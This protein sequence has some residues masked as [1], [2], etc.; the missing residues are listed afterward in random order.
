MYQTGGFLKVAGEKCEECTL[1]GRPVMTGYGNKDADILLV[2]EAPVESEIRRGKPFVSRAGELLD[3]ILS[4]VNIDREDLWITNTCL[5]QPTE[6]KSPTKSE[7]Q[8]CY[9]RLIS[10][11]KEVNPTV[12][13]TMGN[14]ALEALTGKKGITKHI[15]SYEYN[16]TLDAWVI[17]SIHPAAGLR[18]PGWQRDLEVAF[19]LAKSLVEKATIG[20]QIPIH[21]KVIDNPDDFYLRSRYDAVLDLEWSSDQKVLC[22]GLGNEDEVVIYDREVLRDPEVVEEI[23][24][25]IRMNGLIGQNLKSDI[26]VLARDKELGFSDLTLMSTWMDPDGPYRDDTMLMS[27]ALDA[28]KGI[29][30]LKDLAKRLLHVG[31]YDKPI[32]PYIKEMENC[33]K[34][35]M[36]KYNAMDVVYNSLIAKQLREQMNDRVHTLYTQRLMP[37]A[38]ALC[39]MEVRGTFINRLEL[40][41]LESHFTKQL[42][43][44]IQ[45][46]YL[47][48]G[49]EFNIN[50]HQQLASILYD[51]MELPIPL[52]R[53]VNKEAFAMLEEYH[54]IIPAIQQYK[55]LSKIQGTYVQGVASKI[56]PLG[57]IHT[58]FNIHG[59]T[60]GRLSS[61][62]PNLQNIPARTDLGKK[63]K[64]VFIPSRK[65]YT[66]F[67]F[68][69][70]QAE[71]RV[72]A[73][74]SGD[75]TLL[76]AFHNDK[77]IHTVTSA[78]IFGVPMDEVTEE[79]RNIGKTCNF[80]ILYGVSPYGLKK[81]INSTKEE[82]AEAI[83]GWFATYPRAEEFM[84]KQQ[85]KALKEGYVETVTGRVREFPAVGPMNASIM[86]MAGNTPV[87][88][89]AS[90]ITLDAVIRIEKVS[91][92][93][94]FNVLLTVHDSVLLE[95][96]ERTFDVEMVRGI[97][98]KTAEEIVEGKVP[99]VVDVKKGPNWGDMEE[100]E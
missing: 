74:L 10:E 83:K 59:T 31:E 45:E 95:A 88:G 4:K 27:Y 48:A 65:D 47:M 52:Q 22:M 33:P 98:L 35:L 66:L 3:A 64:K 93:L 97:M 87:Q 67:E 17:Y 5:C 94:P 32:K 2:G 38:R 43:D 89:T 63:I 71:L 81:Q 86:R 24:S 44:L 49:E 57:K 16:D 34:D 60:T 91:R 73:Y 90:D 40:A 25:Y 99:F 80:A 61:S 1:T 56:T 36:Y 79:Q 46:I 42:E 13:V 23:E 54:P 50:S 19:H 70:S 58:N 11:I 68:D 51:K 12:I 8:C 69:Y 53:K 84:V 9:A 15:G 39:A 30:G 76:D 92:G 6:N 72:L 37:A 78:G 55:A 29:H 100:I 82:A 41:K 96:D 14:V 62:G 75:E 28:R 18:R 85:H 77:D 21:Y 26:G 7:V 20:D